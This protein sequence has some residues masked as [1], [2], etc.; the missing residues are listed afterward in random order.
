MYSYDDRIRAVELYIK[1][2]KRIRATIRQLGFPTKGALR[3]WYRE[4]KRR[5]DLKKRSRRTP[6]YSKAQQKLAVDHFLD[7]GRSIAFTRKALG[8]PS[9]CLLRSWIYEQHP[10][11]HRRCV[12]RSRP[13]PRSLKIKQQ[14]V[15]AL[16]T[17]RGKAR[18]IAQ[19]LGVARETLHN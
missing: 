3:G 12:G 4:Y 14:A 17:R 5:G 8:Y 2:G 19:D 7:H 11:L 6:K 9:R 16:R 1:L 13:V 18:T 10:E 15:I